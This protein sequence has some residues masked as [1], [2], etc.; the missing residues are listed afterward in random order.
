MICK[1]KERIIYHFPFDIYHF[2]F[3]IFHLPFMCL[4]CDAVLP[5][6]LN[7]K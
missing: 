3:D 7:G 4:N 1:H 6:D 5:N 2:P